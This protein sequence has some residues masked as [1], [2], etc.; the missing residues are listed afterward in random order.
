MCTTCL[1][2]HTVLSPQTALTQVGVYKRDEVDIYI[3]F[4]LRLEVDLEMLFKVRSS[5]T[6]FSPHTFRFACRNK[7]AFS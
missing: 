7:N 5:F 1:F 3:F 2:L 4:F 6:S